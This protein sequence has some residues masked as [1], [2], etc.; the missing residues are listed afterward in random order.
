MTATMSSREKI[1]VVIQP[2]RALRKATPA[3]A[4]GPKVKLAR[5]VPKVSR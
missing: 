2:M 1:S 4:R 3:P 5:I